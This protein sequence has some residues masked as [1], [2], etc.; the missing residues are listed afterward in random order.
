MICLELVFA[1]VLPFLVDATPADRIVGGQPASILAYPYQV[2]LRSTSNS[3]F[4][5]G[6][7]ISNKWILTAAHCLNGRTPSEVIV[8][9]GTNNLN[10]GGVPYGVA[11]FISHSS[12]N[13]GTN[14]NDIALVRISGSISFSTNIKPIQL[15]SNYPGHGANLTL[16]GWGLKSYPSGGVPNILQY[17][18]LIAI[19]INQCKS[20]LSGFPLTSTHLCTIQNKGKG[21]C[22]GDSG[23]PLV[24]NEAQVGI[25]S[26]GIPCAVGLPDIF[27]SVSSYLN[28]IIVN[29]RQ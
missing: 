22:Q 28:W 29:T 25:V 10:S 24:Y 21:A 9:V 3:H 18:N 19:D 27:T 2:S 7:I 8:V 16:T 20:M 12:Y 5:G 6:S 26:W 4:C 1:I 15:S 17:V 13:E 14:V 11:E 23:G